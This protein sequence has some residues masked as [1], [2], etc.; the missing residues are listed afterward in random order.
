MGKEAEIGKE[1]GEHRTRL[2]GKNVERM[3]KLKIKDR[4]NDNN[5]DN[6]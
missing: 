4:G 1:R 6:N 5:S 2:G 3:T